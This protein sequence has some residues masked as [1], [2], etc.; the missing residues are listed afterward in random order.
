MKK[1]LRY[2]GYYLLF[3]VGLFLILT[4]Y[5]W[6]LY[7]Q[8][9]VRGG[10]AKPTF[11]YAR[12]TQEEL[13]KMYPQ[14]PNENVPTRQTP[15]ETYAKFIAALKKGDL[16]EASKQFVEKKQKDWLESLGKIKEKGLLEEFIGDYDQKLINNYKYSTTAQFHIGIEALS[17]AL[18]ERPIDFIKDSNG[19]W[20]IDSL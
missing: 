16:E 17:G 19:D 14:Y 13:N 12:Y 5:N 7:K 18:A 15:E 4:G 3:I 10:H 9:L 11:P 8:Q 2:V 6:Y 1:Y 20:K